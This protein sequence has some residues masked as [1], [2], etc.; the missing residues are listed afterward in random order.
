MEATP[1]ENIY[2][3]QFARF[4]D[5]VE[6][7][8]ENLEGDNLAHGVADALGKLLRE[9]DWLLP[10]YR[11]GAGPLPHPRNSRGL[12]RRLQHRRCGAASGQT[13]PIHDHVSWCVVGLYQG[14]EEEIS[15]HM[16]EQDGERF[17]AKHE[18]EL[19]TAVRSRPPY[20]PR[21][22]YTRSPTPGPE[23]NLHPRLRR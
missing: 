3:E 22:T 4:V 1:K 9:P 12:R 10:E 8:R 16:Y 7:M 5:S 13:T 15:Y 23:S 18:V 6:A 11:K 20:P 17:L 2:A 21:R 19:A 14:E